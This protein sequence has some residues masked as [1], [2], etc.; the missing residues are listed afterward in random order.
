M[1]A[2]VRNASR[3]LLFLLPLLLLLAFF[4][5]LFLPK[6][7]ARE[8]GMEYPTANGFL[9]ETKNTLDAV[10]LGDSIAYHAIIPTEIFAAH[11]ITSYVCASPNQ[12]LCYS[13]ELLE[14][15]FQQQCPKLVLLETDAIYRTVTDENMISSRAERIFPVFRY[16]DRW[17]SLSRRDLSFRVQ[18]ELL[19]TG[20]GYALYRSVDPA[21]SADYM[22]NTDKRAPIKENNLFYLEK[23]RRLCADNGAELILISVPSAVNWNTRK[24]NAVADYAAE[25]QLCF[26]DMNLPKADVRID[27]KTDTCDKGDHLNYRGAKKVTAYLG[28]YLA[29]RDLFTDKREDKEYESWRIAV[30]DFRQ[31][32]D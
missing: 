12:K 31:T 28:D 23:I 4:S 16:H 9:A 32:T 1:R 30:K 3:F 24:H 5:R 22:K 8:D 27:W 14:K 29:G 11:G 15:V 26:I 25:K 18:Y 2:I 6:G 7:N 13:L 17:K 20:K 19:Q 21:P 10:V